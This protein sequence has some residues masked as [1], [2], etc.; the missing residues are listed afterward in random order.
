MQIESCRPHQTE[1]KVI[2]ELYKQTV[3][4]EKFDVLL[5]NDQNNDNSESQDEDD[6]KASQVSSNCFSIDLVVS[7]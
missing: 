1:E 7:F 6:E 4:M 3:D 5:F 2:C